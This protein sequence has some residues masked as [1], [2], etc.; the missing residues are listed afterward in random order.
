MTDGTGTTQYT[1][2]PVGT[3]G[4]LQR[5][6]G[7]ARLPAARSP[8][9][10]KRWGGWPRAPYRAQARRASPTM[11]SAGSP[12]TATTWVRSRSPISA[13]PGRSPAA[14]WPAS[15]LAT[16]WSYLDQHQRP[17]PFGH[18]Q[19]RAD[20]GAVFQLHL[21]HE[22]REL[23]LRHQREQ[24]RLGRLS[25]RYHADRDLQQPQPAYQPLRSDADLRHQRQ[26]H[27]RWPAHLRLG[28]REPAGRHHVPGR[29]RQGDRLHL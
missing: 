20:L 18:Q 2:V 16:S 7:A 5:Q 19:H 26:P 11:R 27:L 24:R 25:R 9:S 28:R 21:H 17:A 14:R 6:T 12:A 29:Q 13:R 10:T 22:P 15:T 8:M 3:F 23:H 1:Y 4:A